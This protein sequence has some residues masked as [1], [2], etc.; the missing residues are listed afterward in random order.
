MAAEHPPHESG[1]RA[2][3]AGTIRSE[4]SRGRHTGDHEHPHA[5]FR[6]N[7][8]KRSFFCLLPDWEYSAEH[9]ETT[10]VSVDF[11]LKK[12]KIVI[13][14]DNFGASYKSRFWK[15]I[16]KQYFNFLFFFFTWKLDNPGGGNRLGRILQFSASI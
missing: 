12:K 10:E 5:E 8:L 16:Q 15:E 14:L 1:R 3:D 11:Y 2:G 7:H 9:R 13:F 6:E 4:D